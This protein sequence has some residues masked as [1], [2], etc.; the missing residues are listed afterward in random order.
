MIAEAG[1]ARAAQRRRPMNFEPVI[2]LD[3]LRAHGAQIVRDGS[4]AIGFLN[5]QLLR[6]A[7]DGCAACQRTGDR[8][9]GQLIDELRDFFP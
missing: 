1:D 2:H 7:N 3:D 4:Y 9:H 8:Q 6:V 5:P